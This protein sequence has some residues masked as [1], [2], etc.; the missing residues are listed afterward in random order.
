MDLPCSLCLKISKDSDLQTIIEKFGENIQNYNM[1]RSFVTCDDPKGVVE[2]GTIRKS[3]SGSHKMEHEIIS[4]KAQKNSKAD[5]TVIAEKKELVSKGIV[6]E[7]RTP[8]SFQLLEV[9]RGAQKL[10]QT[11][12]SWS[13][14]LSSDGQSKDIA[15]DLLKGALDMQE[16]L[17]MLG[18]LQEASHYMAQLKRQKEKLKRQKEKLKI[19][20]VGAEMMNSHQFGDLHCQTGF[21]KPLLSAD[22]SS[23]DYIDELKKAITDSLGRHN[24]L[25]N[26]TTREKTSKERRKR[27]SAPDVPSTSSSQSSVAQSSSSHSTR[28][29]STAA[30][31]RKENSP[32]LIAKLM[33][34]ED[35]P[36]KPL[37]KHPQK[38]LDVETDLSR[39]R[40]R[41]VFDIEM[42]KV[43][44]PQPLMHKVRP[45]QRALKDIL[46]T[47]QF[48]GLLKCHSVKELKSW[49]HH[50]RETNTNRRS[51]NYI[52]PIVLIKP[53]VSCFE[54]KEVPAPM[55]WEMGAL[56][57]ELMPR[58]VKLKKGPE[59]DTRSV[60]YKEGTYSTSKMLRKTEVDEPTNR[61]LGQEEGT[62]DRREVVV[63]PEEKEIKTV[64]Q[65]EVA[66]RENKGNA[67]PEPEETLIKMLGKE[68][69]ED[70][71]YVVPRAE[72]QRIKT[73]LKGSSK[74]KASCPVTNQQQK[75]ETAVKK[76]NKTQRVDTDSRKRIEAEVVKP[77]NV[78]RSQEQAKVISTNTRIEHGS[79]TTKTQITQQ[80]STNQK[81]ILKHTTKTTV[82]GPKDQKRKIVAE[83]T[84]EKP[85]NKELGCKEDKKNGHK[86]DADPVSKVTNTPLAGQPSTEEEANVLKF[87]NEEHCSDS[88]SSPCN[89]TLVTSEHEE[90]TKSPEEANN[91]MGLI[92][93]DGESS[94]NGIQ[95]NALLLSSPL[96]LTRAEELFDLNM[97]S[98]ETFP[99]SGICDYRIA[100]MELSLDYANEYIERRSCVDSQTRHPLLQTCTG[101]SRLNL[102]LE[103]LVEEVVNGAK[104]LTSY[105]KLGFYN[106]PADSLYGILENDIRCGSVA[107]GTWDLGWRN[108]FSV[109]EAEQT[110][111]DV[112]KLLISELIEEMFT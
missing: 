89:H 20:E 91:D 71:K 51:S 5:L 59:P 28:S 74:L 81:S 49:S 23:N 111:N 108:G 3:K 104:T 17:L 30:P 65:E 99:T 110:V 107:S 52:S 45:E 88:Q 41:P 67:E 76:V 19:N 94:K 70:R 4:H 15:K 95:L 98:P 87:H 24:L 55:V 62:K 8:S 50:S 48:K 60:D 40:P 13:K 32:N 96:F 57:A 18:K 21:Q 82:H 78:S 64:V 92:G 73:K 75:K 100:S 85:T 112:E 106:L 69:V 102:S 103:K 1:Y 53:G 84:A 39:R 54:S 9:S 77:K 79:M 56:K 101:D 29:I 7:Y 109:D 80:S 72:E 14:G 42:P 26:R 12:N 46:E 10:N 22:G 44:K 63:K 58:K 11:I 16:S 43:R 61:R 25:P 27:D 68:R 97:N 47:M 35:M 93:G 38:Q 37:Q 105:C 36:S 34:L 66:V 31:P 6:E 83:P 2:C 90:V 86:C 33:G